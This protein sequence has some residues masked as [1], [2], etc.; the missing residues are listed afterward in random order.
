MPVTIK[1][2]LDAAEAAIRE[3]DTEKGQILLGWVL[4]QDSRNV[5]ALLL[6]AKSVADPIAKV[7]YFNR[8]LEVNPTNLHA[9]EGMARYGGQI[10]DPIS[11][12]LPPTVHPPPV[13]DEPGQ[14]DLIQAVGLAKSGRI[15]EAQRSLARIIQRD[16]RNVAAW[17]WLAAAIPDNQKKRA[18]LDA[19]LQIDGENT[20]AK[21]A[22][23]R[24]AALPDWRHSTSPLQDDQHV[25]PPD[26]TAI[27]PRQ[28]ASDAIADRIRNGRHPPDDPYYPP[29]PRAPLPPHSPSSHQ[30][31]GG[32][33][34]AALAS[35]FI[36][37]LGQLAQGRGGAAI[38]YFLAAAFLWAMALGWIVHL[39]AAFD[40]AAWKPPAA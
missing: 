18:C 26:V 8:V 24:L 19:V 14:P 22:M 3:G 30:G 28:K 13:T 20:R 39:I 9:L 38:A 35:F 34:L 16:P 40:A 37:G 33:V 29:Q 5:Q 4:A 12:D 31:S 6:M 23:Q 17:L 11:P 32:N 1:E 21:A 10:P 25:E 2:A 7:K 27:V 15:E 36:P